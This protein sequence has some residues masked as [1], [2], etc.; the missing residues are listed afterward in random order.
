MLPRK[1]GP[2]RMILLI[3]P[4]STISEFSCIIWKYT[5]RK[6]LFSPLLCLHL[7]LWAILVQL[8]L[9]ACLFFQDCVSNIMKHA[10]E[11]N[12]PMV[13]DGVCD[14]IIIL[15]ANCLIFDMAFILD[16]PLV[17]FF[18]LSGWAFSRD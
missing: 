9:I 8:D 11:C 1:I 14:G 7:L 4:G 18:V 10:R 6:F 12:V 3:L 17:V 16:M 13:I 5:C 15:Q 2:P